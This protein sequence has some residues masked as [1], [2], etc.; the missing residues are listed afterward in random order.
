M[1]TWALGL[2]ELQGAGPC[3]PCQSLR[4]EWVGV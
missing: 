3:Y 4:Q 1:L 2:L